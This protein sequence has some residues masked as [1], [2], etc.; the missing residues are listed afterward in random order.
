M[1]L[2]DFSEKIAILNN[3]KKLKGT[4]ISINSDYSQATL[5]KRRLLWSSAKSQKDSGDR[6]QLIHDKLKINGELFYWN[7]E[8][9]CRETVARARTDNA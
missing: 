7:E 6:V 5:E 8:A 3:C 4:R 1:K 9:K 2:F